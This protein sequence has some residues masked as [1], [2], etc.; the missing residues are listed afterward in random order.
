MTLEEL[1]IK[2]HNL[3]QA[4]LKLIQDFEDET[5]LS[6]D[7]ELGRAHSFDRKYQQV[8]AVKAKIEL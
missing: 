8:V 6:V 3:E 2:Q 5:K 1:A 7:F 4:M